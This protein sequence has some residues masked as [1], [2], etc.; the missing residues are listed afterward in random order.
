[1]RK[2]GNMANDAKITIEVEIDS[3]G[4]QL[5]KNL[6]EAT[7]EFKKFDSAATVAK[8]AINNL[9]LTQLF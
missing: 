7:K 5:E 6:K 1:M 3:K 8:K 9:S 2:R 4:V